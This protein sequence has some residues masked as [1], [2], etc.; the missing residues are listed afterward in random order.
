MGLVPRPEDRAHGEHGGQAGHR[1]WDCNLA[2][3]SAKAYEYLHRVCCSGVSVL[4][5]QLSCFCLNLF[6]LENIQP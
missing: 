3:F 1:H 6:S 5:G 2:C 4:L